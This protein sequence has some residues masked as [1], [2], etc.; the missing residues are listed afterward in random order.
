LGSESD[1]YMRQ[2]GFGDGTFD[3][4]MINLSIIVASLPLVIEISV[5]AFGYCRDCAMSGESVGLLRRL[6]DL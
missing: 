3:S 1:G 4:N 2:F 6:M 5:G